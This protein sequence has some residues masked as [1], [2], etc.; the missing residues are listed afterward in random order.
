MIIVN[1]LLTILFWVMSDIAWAEDRKF[2]A[3]VYL[4]ASALNGAALM[5]VVF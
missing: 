4:F 2:W 5:S 3:H 1:I